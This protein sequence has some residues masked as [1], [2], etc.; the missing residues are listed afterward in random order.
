MRVL[1]SFGLPYQG[2][3]NLLAP[4]IID[5]IPACDSFLDACCGGGA[6]TQAAYVSGKF[7]KVTA[8][9]TFAPIVRLLKAVMC[10]PGSIDYEHFPFVTKED[11]D[12][13]RKN[14]QTLEDSVKLFTHSFGFKGN[15]YAW[16]PERVPWKRLFHEAVLGITA[17]QRR[18]ALMTMLKRFKDEKKGP[19]WITM[20]NHPEELTSLNR[21]HKMETA[22]RE[23]GSTTELDISVG[24][25][26]DID[27]DKFD[28]IYFDP[29]YRGTL[30]YR[31]KRFDFDRFDSLLR[32][33]TQRG[34]PVFVSEYSELPGFRLI[35]EFRK[36]STMDA[37]Q[38][39]MVT[40]RVWWNGV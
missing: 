5:L 3:K 31:Y 10:E 7:K 40:E 15:T 18:M 26:F 30:K 20:L 21:I 13:T 17:E 1:K 32:D 33:L 25:L 37:T 38:N 28:V 12:A 16:N 2:S 29:P 27:F 4:K 36:L 19:T 14:P 35:G 6:V 34:K 23:N 39:R 9:D 11:F 22:C 8:V 24:N